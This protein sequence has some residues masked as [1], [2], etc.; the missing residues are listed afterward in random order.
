M[1]SKKLILSTYAIIL[2]LGITSLFTDIHYFA[3]IAGFIG[4]VGLMLIF[5]KDPSSEEM[6]E[7][8]MREEKQIKKRW[9]IVFI[10][11]I[12]FSLIFGS[13]WNDDFGNMS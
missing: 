11:G 8:E 6:T 13:F 2:A 1:H 9:Y 12:L 5:F 4:G 3:N 7:E 10:T